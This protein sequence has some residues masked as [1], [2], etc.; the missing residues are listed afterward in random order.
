MGMGKFDIDA[1][2]LLFRQI[3]RRKKYFNSL[4]KKRDIKYNSKW[5][6]INNFGLEVGESRL[7]SFHARRV[8]HVGVD[9]EGVRVDVEDVAEFVEHLHESDRIS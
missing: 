4:R 9:E 2:K 7:E 1:A 5:S 3:E 6:Y 8:G